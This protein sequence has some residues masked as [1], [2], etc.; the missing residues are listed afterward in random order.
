VTIGLTIPEEAL[1]RVLRAW[2]TG[3]PQSPRIGFVSLDELKA[4]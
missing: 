3:E 1:E 4:A 2:E